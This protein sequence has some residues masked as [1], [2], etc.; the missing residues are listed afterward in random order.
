MIALK[1][2]EFAVKNAFLLSRLYTQPTER[3]RKR[4]VVFHSDN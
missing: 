4:I 2:L 1:T 3:E